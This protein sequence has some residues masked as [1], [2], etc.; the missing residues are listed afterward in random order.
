MNLAGI[1]LFAALPTEI[2][3]SDCAVGLW[4]VPHYGQPYAIAAG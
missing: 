3:K 2:K 4:I 1:D